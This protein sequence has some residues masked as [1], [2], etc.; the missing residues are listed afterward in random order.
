MAG[1]ADGLGLGKELMGHSLLQLSSYTT[2]HLGAHFDSSHAKTV[3]EFEML[4]ETMGKRK[5]DHSAASWQ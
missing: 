4:K 1:P 3:S 2:I 5:G